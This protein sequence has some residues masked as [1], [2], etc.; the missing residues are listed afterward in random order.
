VKQSRSM[1]CSRAGGGDVLRAKLSR[2]RV[3]RSSGIEGEAVEATACSRGK[4]V[5][6]ALRRWRLAPGIGSVEDLK[7]VSG[8]NLLSVERATR[9][10]LIFILGARCTTHVH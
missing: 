3:K 10:H 4:E 7:C 8:K 6:G 2:S 1:T 5:E 9:A